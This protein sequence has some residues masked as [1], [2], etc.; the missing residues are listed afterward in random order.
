MK[1]KIL[2]Q[3]LIFLLILS[4]SFFAYLK[5][6]NHFKT[7]EN[8]I[9]DTMFK[10][11]GKVKA[12]SNIVIVDIDEKSLYEL[13][14]WPWSRDVVAQVLQNLADY[15]VGIIGLD[16][17]FAEHDNSSPKRVLKKLGIENKNVEDYDEIL[18]AAIANTPTVVGYVFALQDDGILA[19]TSPK[20]TAI[21]IEKNKPI[22]SYLIR[23]HR[24]ILNIP[25]IQDN[26]YSNGYFNTIPD[27]DG[28]VRSIPMVMDYDG[29]LYPS[30]SLEM[31][32]LMLGESKIVINYQ[33][34]G[35]ESVSIGDHIIPTDIFG[36][37]MVNYRGNQHS[38]NYISAS[39]I[40]YK[41]ISFEKIKNK[42]VLIGTSAAG[43]LDLRSTP[44]ENVFPGVEV[45]ANA[46]DNI[47]NQDFLASPSWVYGADLLSIFVLLLIVLGILMIPNVITS[48][49]LLFVVNIFL[50][51]VH[52][53][54]MVY[55]GIVLNTL[56]P[57]LG[58]NLLFF[59]GESYN[60]F[61]EN[62]LK[63]RIKNKFASKVSSAVVEELIKGKNEGVL[64]GKE[65]E[66]TIFFSDIRGF[67]PLCEK[68]SSA[69]KIIEL[70]NQY[71]TPMVDIIV[72]YEGTIDKFIGD[73]IM[74]YW[75]APLRV[76]N[77]ADKA[78]KTAIEQIR[79]LEE[80]NATLTQEHKPNINIGIGINTGD[81]IVGEMGSSGRSD[82]TCVGDSVNLA[83]RVEGLCKVYGSNIVITEFTK[84]LL[85]DEYELIELD[86]VRVKGKDEPI[87]IY[88][89][90]GDK[91]YIW[92]NYKD[93]VHDYN[94]AMSLYRNSKFDLAY[95][96]FKL[97]NETNTQKVY[98][99]YLERC[100]YFVKN[101][102]E[103][104]DGV[105]TFDVK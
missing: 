78:L 71:M 20:D 62:K 82:Y 2:I 88:E 21:V 102:L 22:N 47:I 95:K 52:Y 31:V 64:E 85:V 48:F 92:K 61:L 9:N 3:F 97:L 91:S 42:I 77:H 43:L 87:K 72:K 65:E 104:F 99:L 27:E 68:L 12:D 90:Y 7:F 26:A 16:I 29:F 89:C 19:K 103:D 75:N 23:T 57:L 60:Y 49:V 59:L 50:L 39:D 24:A 40:Y 6:P 46:I 15:G 69:Q 58:I 8:K 51:I 13:G 84:S 70:L 30:L 100:D 53:Y 25:T 11:R 37:L 28:I 32:K 18:A 38:Y 1:K 56:L 67:T 41:R 79:A 98:E 34:K 73:A 14:Q 45:H 4:S 105:F 44:F 63:I 80:L 76:K 94:E 17:V 54:I 81:C 101:P 35:V 33:Q 36:R 10:I 83:S 74:A 55:E 93:D 66:I 96:K 5:Y 86:V